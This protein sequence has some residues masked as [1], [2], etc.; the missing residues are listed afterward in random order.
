SRSPLFPYTTL[1]RSDFATFQSFLQK[2]AFTFDTRT[3]EAIRALRTVAGEEAFS[4]DLDQQIQGLAQQ[5]GKEKDAQ[6]RK[7][8]KEILKAIEREILVRYYFETGLV[9]HQL[10]NDPEL[11]EA[12]AVL[13]AP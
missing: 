8:E 13:N 12:I 5:L 4:A 2:S 10:K 7:H 1:F 6:V 3:D 9:R 11:K